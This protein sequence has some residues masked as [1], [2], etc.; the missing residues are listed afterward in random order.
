MVRIHD[1]IDGFNQFSQSTSIHGLRYIGDKDKNV[2]ARLIWIVIVVTSF[3]GA[4]III[5]QSVQ[6]MTNTSLPRNVRYK[7][8]VYY[9]C[10]ILDYYIFFLCIQFSGFFLV[11]LIDISQ[12]YFL[13][14][15]IKV[16]HMLQN[17]QGIQ[18]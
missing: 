4:I 7:V 13:C 10:F 1:L 6:G 12:K 14:L 3:V 5:S 11:S 2:M 15:F 9:L 8:T 18:C 17:G 16:K